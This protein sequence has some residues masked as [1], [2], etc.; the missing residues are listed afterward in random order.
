MLIQFAALGKFDFTKFHCEPNAK[1][2][3]KQFKKQMAIYH[4]H[5]YSK[6]NQR[7]LDREVNAQ[8]PITYKILSPEPK[9]TRRSDHME[10]NL[11]ELK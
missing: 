9:R 1:D 10:T 8:L 7:I 4:K 5:C 6:Y 11:G 3:E 2:I